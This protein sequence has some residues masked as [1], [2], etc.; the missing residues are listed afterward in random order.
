VGDG[1]VVETKVNPPSIPAGAPPLLAI[2]GG[3]AFL[4]TGPADSA[5]AITHVVPLGES[6]R[7]AFVEFGG[8]LVIWENGSEIGR[9]AVDALP[10]A[11][12]LVDGQERVLLLTKPSSRY[13]H[14]ISG[15]TLEAAEITLLETSPSLQVVTQISIPG[16][17]VVEG[18]TPIWADLNGDGQWEIIVTL[19]DAEQGAQVVVYSESGKQV[20]AGPAVGRGNRWRQ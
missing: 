4:I 6:G 9:L 16:Q 10:D 13:P 19:S 11:R 8:D 2:S 20:A 15:D 18:I 17:R 5:S 7:L 14:G 3:E 12:L 1:Q